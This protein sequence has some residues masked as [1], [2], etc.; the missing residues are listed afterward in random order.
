M[1]TMNAIRS[2]VPVSSHDKEHPDDNDDGA[3]LDDEPQDLV[4]REEGLL[5]R[6]T[7]GTRLGWVLFLAG[8]LIAVALLDYLWPLIPPLFKSPLFLLS[9]GYLP[10]IAVTVLLTRQ[11]MLTYWEQ[12]DIVPLFTGDTVVEKI[13]KV[14]GTEG[15]DPSMK[16]LDS[17]GFAGLS[18]RYKTIDEEF[19]REEPL[20]QKIDRR[21]SD[22]SWESSRGLLDNAYTASG[23]SEV[24][25]TLYVSHCE[26]TTEKERASSHE[27]RTSP[28][29]RPD[30]D[31]AQE[32]AKRDKL[33]REEIIPGFKSQ[34]STKDDRMAKL[35]NEALDKPLVKLEEIPALL[36]ELGVTG[37]AEQFGA[38]VGSEAAVDDIDQQVAE[39]MEE[40]YE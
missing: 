17:V 34:L 30:M 22:G 12:F 25:G 2:R 18:P 36:E 39:E 31:A 19:T 1:S 14:D 8:A 24:F 32:V 20:M 33:L 6:L 29:R 27:W 26:G 21:N 11:S 35:E 9:V 13:G 7:P 23:R 37:N 15:R 28:P 38:G 40:D 4:H 10:A 16:V 5:S 3:T